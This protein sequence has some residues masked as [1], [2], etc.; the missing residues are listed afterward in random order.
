MMSGDEIMMYAD[1][2]WRNGFLK[3]CIRGNITNMKKLFFFCGKSACH[4]V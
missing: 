2:K 3:D 1:I 4:F